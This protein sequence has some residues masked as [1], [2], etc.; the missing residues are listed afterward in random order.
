[1]FD[2]HDLISLEAG[3][4]E[5]DGWGPGPWELGLRR[6]W[7]GTLAGAQSDSSLPKASSVLGLLRRGGDSAPGRSEQRV[8]DVC[9]SAEKYLPDVF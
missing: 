4:N 2:Y 1:M 8:L 5:T 7:E 3:D 6:A 9:S